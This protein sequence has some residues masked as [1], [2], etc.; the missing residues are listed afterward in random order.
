[1]EVIIH[2]VNTISKLKSI[3][4]IYGTEIDIRSSGSNLIL[5]HDPFKSGDKLE[6]YV[7]E[8]KNS[9]LILNIKEAGIERDVL[10]II[11]GRPHVKKYFLLDTDFPYIY[12]A[13][14]EGERNLAIRFSEFES[15]ETLKNFSDIVDYVWIDTFLKLPI[16]NKNIPVL[17][18]FKKCL[19][20]PERWGR[21]E[22]IKH[23]QKQLKS[24]N[25]KI[26]S[27]MTSKKYSSL[28]KNFS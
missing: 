4:P 16:E 23:Y 21:P 22:D 28:W 25:F 24:Y 14:K 2:R 9:T 5:S 27:V 11:K 17:N 19:V 18:K 6:D 8:Y 13:S 1:M 26:N 12:K 10:S 15:I 20:C 3:Q 7:D